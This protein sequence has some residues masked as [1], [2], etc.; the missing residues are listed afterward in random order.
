MRSASNKVALYL[1][2]A[3]LTLG[4]GRALGQLV[5]ST[6]SVAVI[7]EELL[8]AYNFLMRQSTSFHAAIDEL[9]RIGFKVVIGYHDDF[10]QPYPPPLFG[11]LAQVKPLLRGNNSRSLYGVHIV[12]HTRE[13]EA[14]ARAA[15][16]SN[17]TI[18]RELAIVL[19]HE[20][21]GHVVPAARTATYPSPCADPSWDVAGQEMGCAVERE[22]QIRHEIGS[23]ERPHYRV[24]DLS[25]F[26]VSNES[27]CPTPDPTP[28][29]RPAKP[30][31]PK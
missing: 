22:N 24:V 31:R 10:E 28:P 7:S 29:S 18:T 21:Y 9:E 14:G 27:A 30:Q 25:F 15:G 2:G 26:C 3:F 13:M 1:A 19:A 5:P 11:A 8:P 20:L 23:G 16:I 17:E 4:A 12:F 6:S